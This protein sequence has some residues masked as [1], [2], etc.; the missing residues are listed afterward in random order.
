VSVFVASGTGLRA[1]SDGNTSAVIPI[2]G[3]LAIFT[4]PIPPGDFWS[5]RLEVLDRGTSL[6]T[7]PVTHILEDPFEVGP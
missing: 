4:L 2:S 7:F 1:V 5:Y 6:G 3:Q